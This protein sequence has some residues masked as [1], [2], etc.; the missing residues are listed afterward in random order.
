[1]IGDSPWN[2]V[3]RGETWMLVYGVREIYS[4]ILPV[5]DSTSED[6][7]KRLMEFLNDDVA[8]REGN[9]TRIIK[10]GERLGR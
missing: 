6:E 3:K 10:R 5:G 4:P 1:M 2:V 7:A 8:N 9:L